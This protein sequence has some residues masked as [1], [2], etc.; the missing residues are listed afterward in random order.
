MKRGPKPDPTKLQSRHRPKTSWREWPEDILLRHNYL[1]MFRHFSPYSLIELA[2]FLDVSA[3]VLDRYLL[4]NK[5]LNGR[6]WGKIYQKI[7]GHVE[8]RFFSVQKKRG[9]RKPNCRLDKLRRRVDGGRPWQSQ[10]GIMDALKKASTN[11]PKS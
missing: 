11:E 2:I 10:P 8:E 4:R 3:S 1:R 9:N 5:P 6:A 7:S